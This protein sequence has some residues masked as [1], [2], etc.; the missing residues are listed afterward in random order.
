MVPGASKLLASL[1]LFCSFSNA[2]FQVI[3]SPHVIR[4]ACTISHCESWG[5]TEE[6]FSRGSY[7]QH[8]QLLLHDHQV[9]QR[10]QRQWTAALLRRLWI[11]SG[12]DRPI[13]LAQQQFAGFRAM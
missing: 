1:A 5:L 7:E 8:L 11:P 3:N 6:C 13:R 4:E 2:H 9:L 12:R 10:G